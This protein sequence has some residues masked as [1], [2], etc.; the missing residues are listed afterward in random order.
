MVG[1]ILGASGEQYRSSPSSAAHGVA[2]RM[3]AAI[4]IKSARTT[5]SSDRDIVETER[6]NVDVI[7][8]DRRSDFVT[9]QGLDRACIYKQPRYAG[10]R[11]VRLADPLEMS[12]RRLQSS[13]T[14]ATGGM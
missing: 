5:E 3:K 12:R 8:R 4:K 13:A 6:F 14:S 10:I 1:G 9:L 2:N 7:G 11:A